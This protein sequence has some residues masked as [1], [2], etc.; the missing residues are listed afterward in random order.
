MNQP[1]LDERGNPITQKTSTKDKALKFFEFLKSKV[2]MTIGGLAILALVLTNL[3]KVN[4]FLFPKKLEI[5]DFNFLSQNIRDY[6]DTLDLKLINPSS[7]IFYVKE[8]RFNFKETWDVKHVAE[9][10]VLYLDYSS[11][12]VLKNVVRLKKSNDNANPQII[13]LKLS[14]DISP[15]KADRIAIV[16]PALNES[17]F[18]SFNVEIFYNKNQKIVSKDYLHFF[19]KTPRWCIPE[20]NDGV[21]VANKRCGVHSDVSNEKEQERRKKI[22]QHNKDI[23]EELKAITNYELTPKAK[24]V[25]DKISKTFAN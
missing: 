23:V 10:P 17:L 24:I 18:A 11:K 4:S 5:V 3:A 7:S 13:T 12:Y 22:F 19:P 14:Q 2:T 20:L 6:Q 21:F 1:I 16:I 8:I 25:L 15:N 9:G